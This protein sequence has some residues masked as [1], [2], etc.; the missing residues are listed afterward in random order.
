MRRVLGVPVGWPRSI[1]VA[2][3]VALST[4]GLVALAVEQ[5]FTTG[6]GRDVSPGPAIILGLIALMWMLGFGAALLTVMELVVP[7][8]AGFSPGG[9]AGRSGR[10]GGSRIGRQRA[11]NRRYRQVMAIFVRKGLT[12]RKPSMTEAAKA[13]RDPEESAPPSS[14]WVRT[15]RPDSVLPPEFIRSSRR[16]RPGR[17]RNRG[18]Y[19]PG[20]GRVPGADRTVFATVE[21]E[22]MAAASVAQCRATLDD[23]TR[24]P[25]G[26]AS[27]YPRGGAQRH[28]HR[29][30]CTLEFRTDWGREM[31]IRRL[32]RPSPAPWPRSWTTGARWQHAR[33]GRT[34][35]FHEGA[36]AA[37]VR[38]YSSERLLVMDELDGT[39]LG[40]VDLDDYSTE[41]RRGL[42]S[43]LMVSV[44]VR[45]GYG[46]FRLTHTRAISW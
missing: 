9:S 2:L 5:F 10:S 41:Q 40:S 20:H 8:G 24:G 45:S 6:G 29:W 39:P 14:S 38:Q 12:A 23:G 26:A 21:R 22:P 18:A 15:C 37:G 19:R 7:T 30:I 3:L 31:G 36:H 33:T 27:R 11:R 13:F 42:D 44:C 28:R 16:C 4:G 17:R 1:L 25:E 43:A 32:V 46:V 35:A 34:A